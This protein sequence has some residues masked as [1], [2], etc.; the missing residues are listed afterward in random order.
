[1]SSTIEEPSRERFS[2]TIDQPSSEVSPSVAPPYSA[3]TP[4]QRWLITALVSYAA[5]FSTT[6]SFVYYPAISSLTSDFDVSVSDI[7]LTVTTYMAV[8]TVAPTLV[9][10]AA[11]VLGRRPVYGITLVLYCVANAA[12]V[13]ADSY[14]ALLGLRVLQALANVSPEVATDGRRTVDVDAVAGGRFP[15]VPTAFGGA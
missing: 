13:L 9:G 3:F 15:A 2:P 4:F 12:I 5:C 7:N 11:D 1:M 14:R 8:A 6:T 10:D